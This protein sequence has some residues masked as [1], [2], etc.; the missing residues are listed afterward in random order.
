MF[1]AEMLAMLRVNPPTRKDDITTPFFPS[2]FSLRSKYLTNDPLDKA[3]REVVGALGFNILLARDLGRFVVDDAHNKNKLIDDVFVLAEEI[4]VQVD[5]QR[6][7]MDR[8]SLWVHEMIAIIASL[9]AGAAS[10]PQS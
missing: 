3:N 2:A 4:R 9:A 10:R 8:A 7:Y 5:E 1:A 6:K